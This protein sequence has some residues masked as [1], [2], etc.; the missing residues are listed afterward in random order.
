MIS[1]MMHVAV[2]MFRIFDCWVGWVMGIFGC[3]RLPSCCARIRNRLAVV[4]WRV[5]EPHIGALSQPSGQSKFSSTWRIQPRHSLLQRD[6]IKNPVWHPFFYN[7]DPTW[8]KQ[9]EMLPCWRYGSSTYD[10]SR[11]EIGAAYC[12]VSQVR[13]LNINKGIVSSVSLPIQHTG[14]GPAWNLKYWSE[15][16]RMHKMGY[17][18]STDVPKMQ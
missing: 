15:D 4:P 1:S 2:S 13:Q 3:K 14:P 9:N 6:Q 12:S 17:L 16:F 7:W 11:S 10:R 5:R 8:S 18:L